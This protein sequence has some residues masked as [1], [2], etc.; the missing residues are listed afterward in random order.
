LKGAKPADLPIE[1]P[2]KFALEINVK[3]ARLIPHLQEHLL[4]SASAASS[5]WCRRRYDVF[6]VTSSMAA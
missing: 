3:T 2:T 5:Y 6:R 4:H 1:Q